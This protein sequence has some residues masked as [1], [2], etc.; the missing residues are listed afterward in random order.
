MVNKHFGQFNVHAL[1][2]EDGLPFLN[3]RWPYFTPKVYPTN[4]HI[5]FS[6][7]NTYGRATTDLPAVGQQMTRLHQI[8]R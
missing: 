4:P 5:F 8:G 7:I 1:Y 2:Q 3:A 6:S